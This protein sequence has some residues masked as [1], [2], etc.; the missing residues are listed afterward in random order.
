MPSLREICIVAK[1]YKW[2]FSLMAWFK[3]TRDQ[4]KGEALLSNLEMAARFFDPE[5]PARSMS[6][7]TGAHKALVAIV[8]SEAG[9]IFTEAGWKYVLEGALGLK[10]LAQATPGL[11]Q[12][13]SECDS[14]A[15]QADW[16]ISQCE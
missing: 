9:Y 8:K 6:H 7:V 4:M 15:H 3:S 5:K 12:M 16:F 1:K 11:K 2:Y 13:E 10:L 14:I